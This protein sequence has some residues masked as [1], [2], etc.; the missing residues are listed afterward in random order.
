MARIP[1]VLVREPAL[2]QRREDGVVDRDAVHGHLHRMQASCADPQAGAIEKTYYLWKNQYVD[3]LMN[4]LRELRQLRK[5]KSS[6]LVP[7]LTL[8]KVML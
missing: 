4:E 7:D 3:L 1:D 8:Y 2:A 5:E 6:R